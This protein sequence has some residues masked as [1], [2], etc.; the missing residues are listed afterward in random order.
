MFFLPEI[1][2]LIALAANPRIAVSDVFAKPQPQFVLSHRYCIL[3]SPIVFQGVSWLGQF[4]EDPAME[5]LACA[6]LP[7]RRCGSSAAAPHLRNENTPSSIKIDL[8]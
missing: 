8:W 5:A 4:V 6:I 2:A 7:L 3:S 1:L